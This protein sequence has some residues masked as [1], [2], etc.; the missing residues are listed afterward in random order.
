MIGF[1]EQLTQQTGI[2][3]AE[4][5][6]PVA[7][8]SLPDTTPDIV[9]VEVIDPLPSSPTVSESSDGHTP[10]QP[11]SDSR[12]EYQ[13]ESIEIQDSTDLTH[14]EAI[15]QPQPTTSAPQR[16]PESL[17]DAAT[18]DSTRA[19]GPDPSHT[20]KATR[21]RDPDA[22]PTAAA[23]L[24]AVFSWIAAGDSKALPIDDLVERSTRQDAD[25]SAIEIE[26]PIREQLDEPTSLTIPDTRELPGAQLESERP[27]SLEASQPTARAFSQSAIARPKSTRDSSKSPRESSPPPSIRIGSINVTIDAPK[28]PEPH[29]RSTPPA[30]AQTERANRTSNYLRRHY[31]L[32][33]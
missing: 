10:R 15:A 20:S 1:L 31:I 13:I 26:T 21:T 23:A 27:S 9:E 22:Q 8:F 19:S 18:P 14:Q 2:R 28:P 29:A 24:Q 30:S 4:R 32:P 33:H 6:A 7:D 16:N 3:I 12:T 11:S 17:S 25:Q 5:V